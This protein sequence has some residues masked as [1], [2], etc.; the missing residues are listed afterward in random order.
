MNFVSLD[1]RYGSRKVHAAALFSSRT[2]IVFDHRRFRFRAFVVCRTEL[3][4]FAR[5]HLC[6]P[7]GL[8]LPGSPVVCQLTK[9]F[10]KLSGIFLNTSHSVGCGGCLVLISLNPFHFHW[11]SAVGLT[12]LRALIVRLL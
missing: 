10:S 7:R 6:P 4:S 9:G 11:L 5:R 1:A 3:T 2:S 12:N 8:N